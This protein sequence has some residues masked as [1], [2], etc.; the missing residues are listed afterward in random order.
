M[1]RLLNTRYDTF[2]EQ[3][4]YITSKANKA[5]RQW[6]WTIVPQVMELCNVPCGDNGTA[7]VVHEQVRTDETGTIVSPR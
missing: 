2:V 6:T 7:D 5:W 4:G 3:Y 1:Q